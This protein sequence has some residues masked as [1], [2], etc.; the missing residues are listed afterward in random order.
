MQYKDGILRLIETQ[1][2]PTKAGELYRALG[3]YHR[4]ILDDTGLGHKILPLVV[5]DEPIKVG[6]K[7][8]HPTVGVV[9]CL[10][11]DN[12][13][14]D[15]GSYR[16]DNTVDPNKNWLV[17]LKGSNDRPYK[18]LVDSYQIPSNVIDLVI[19]DHLKDGNTVNVEVTNQCASVDYNNCAEHHS[20][21]NVIECNYCNK[22]P[23][24]GKDDKA[25]ILVLIFKDEDSPKPKTGLT[26]T[27]AAFIDLEAERNEWK[28]AYKLVSDALEAIKNRQTEHDIQKVAL[29]LF[30][31]EPGQSFEGYNHPDAK[32]ELYAKGRQ[33]ERNLWLTIQKGNYT[34]PLELVKEAYRKW[35]EEDATPKFKKLID[36]SVEHLERII[37]V[38][39][40]GYLWRELCELQKKLKDYVK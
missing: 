13:S 15:T 23:C 18:V 22:V 3:Q 17:Y 37:N 5:V 38:V 30:P 6:E 10:E 11:V 29:E 9:E 4:L 25:I 26:Y 21:D 12:W 8:F 2:V 27:E 19:Q 34:I 35:S 28:N 39:D 14:E 24:L 36:E 20:Y 40:N 33:D 32:R 16:F 31:D 1:D 7:M